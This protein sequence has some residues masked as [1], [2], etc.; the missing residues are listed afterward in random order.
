MPKR[1]EAKRS[2]WTIEEGKWERPGMRKDSE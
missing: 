2:M 1:E